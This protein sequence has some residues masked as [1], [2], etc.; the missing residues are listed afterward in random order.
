MESEVDESADYLLV[1][2]EPFKSSHAYDDLEV[3]KVQLYQT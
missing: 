1:E 3:V 2:A